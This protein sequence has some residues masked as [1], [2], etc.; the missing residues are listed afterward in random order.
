[1]KKII[2]LI[3]VLLSIT[4]VSCGKDSSNNESVENT[5]KQVENQESVQLKNNITKNECMNG[6]YMM[7]KSNPGNKDKTETDM[8]QNCEDLCNAS[9]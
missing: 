1:M 6:C 7:W 3:M 9:Q 8:N 2:V 4:L 5:E